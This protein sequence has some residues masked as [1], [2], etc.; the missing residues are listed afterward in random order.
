[1]DGSVACVN[2][3]LVVHTVTM[4]NVPD[5]R[6]VI[7]KRSE[8]VIGFPVRPKAAGALEKSFASQQGSRHFREGRTIQRHSH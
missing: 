4:L 2:S 6:I 1:M 5:S 8:A 3:I 7:A